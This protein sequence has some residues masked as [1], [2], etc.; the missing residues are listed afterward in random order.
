MASGCT[1]GVPT[2][3]YS[4]RRLPRV[5]HPE[6]SDCIRK[7]PVSLTS[8]RVIGKNDRDVD[9]LMDIAA[10]SAITQ[11]PEM[12]PEPDIFRPERFLDATNPKLANFTI[13]FGFG[14]RICPG[15]HVASQSVYIA[16]SRCVGY[17]RADIQG[18]D[19]YWGQTQIGYSGR[20]TSLQRRMN[21]E[22]QS[23]RRPR[24]TRPG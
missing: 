5:L 12:F 2:C 16:I 7:Y 9:V 3:S 8:W 10:P 21:T 24:R 13:P 20:S 17:L 22:K 11:D 4:G 23:C 15:M 1:N 14:R 6:R 19:R 18:A